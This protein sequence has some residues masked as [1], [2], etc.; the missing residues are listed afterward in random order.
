MRC[1]SGSRVWLPAGD[2]Q[3][4]L[5]C[6]AEVRHSGARSHR[7]RAV[8]GAVRPHGKLCN[9]CL[10]QDTLFQLRIARALALPRIN[11]NTTTVTVLTTT[12][13][14]TL[15]LGVCMCFSS[16]P[17]SQGDHGGSTMSTSPCS[18][19]RASLVSLVKTHLTK[20]PSQG[21]HLRTGKERRVP[22]TD[23]RS[24]SAC[25]VLPHQSST[26]RE[27]G[28]PCLDVVLC[29][30]LS[31]ALSQVHRQGDVGE[32]VDGVKVEMLIVKA[33]SSSEKWIMR[34]VRTRFVSTLFSIVFFF[35]C[36]S[37]FSV[38]L[39]RRLCAVSFFLTIVW[40]VR[41]VHLIFA[42]PQIKEQIV[43]ATA[44][45]DVHI[46]YRG[47]NTAEQIVAVPQIQEHN[48]EVIKVI[49]QVSVSK[50][51]YFLGGSCGQ[52]GKSVLPHSLSRTRSVGVF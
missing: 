40:K 47:D 44:L 10:A 25:I 2:E 21:G 9:C 4:G 34:V 6:D 20:P 11:C 23:R 1:S 5:A 50:C 38:K 7:V 48:V 39:L 46:F 43:Q 28:F 24:N 17:S 42:V 49:L 45:V 3:R 14:T 15:S 51:F 29:S 41:L 36:R 33:I 31:N 32:E 16:Q 8:V 30:L 37:Q 27:R 19:A 13:E 26:Q 12:A 35:Y 52:H 22:A 18:S